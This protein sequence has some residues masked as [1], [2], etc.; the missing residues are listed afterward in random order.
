M[1]RDTIDIEM[2]DIRNWPWKII[3]I[4]LLALDLVFVNLIAIRS[5]LTSKISDNI[6][7]NLVSPEND[8]AATIQAPTPTACPLICVNE[9]NQLISKSLATVSA[10]AKVIEKIVQPTMKPAQPAQ[11]Q[12]KSAYIPLLSSGSSTK[13]EWETYVPSDFYFDLS[14]Y[15]GAK[16]V[17]FIAYLK[18]TDGS[19]KAFARLYDA[20]NN[21]AVDYSDLQSFS[22]TY[23]LVVSSPLTV[24]RGNNLYRIQLKSLNGSATALQEA[25]LKVNY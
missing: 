21:R 22:Q 3:I 4:V 14:D 17:Q 23:E 7:T 18:A 5:I 1:I 9:F 24:W 12:A 13:M 6:V 15:P 10:S 19:G 16:S 8:S 2:L 11:Q 20:S 25:K